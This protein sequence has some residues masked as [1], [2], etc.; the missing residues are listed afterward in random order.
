MPGPQNEFTETELVHLI[1]AIT[2]INAW[3]RFGVSTRMVPGHY[4]PAPT[5]RPSR[6]PIFVH[7]ITPII[8][9]DAHNR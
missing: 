8:L 1:G 5:H 7:T 3:N 6:P 9:K 4:T 2:M